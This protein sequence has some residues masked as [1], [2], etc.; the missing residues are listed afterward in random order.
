MVINLI[1]D[2]ENWIWNLNWG[3]GPR[4]GG[5]SSLKIYTSK[6]FKYI[7]LFQRNKALPSKWIKNNGFD[8]V[9]TSIVHFLISKRTF[10]F[11]FNFYGNF[12]L[13]FRTILWISKTFGLSHFH[14][15]IKID[16]I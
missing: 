5:S 11:N 14:K 2:S 6:K 7:P 12:D 3:C 8:S 4:Q 10:D 9:F 15:K 16:L 1:R 13:V